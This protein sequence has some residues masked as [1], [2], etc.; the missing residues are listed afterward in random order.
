GKGRAALATYDAMARR[1]HAV[2]VIEAERIA[3]EGRAEAQARS[4][5]R[6]G[7]AETLEI[8]ADRVDDESI[9]APLGEGRE[10]VV[11]AREHGDARRIELL[12]E[13]NEP[14]AALAHLR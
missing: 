13:L 6:A 5:D 1:A 14:R 11:G 2:G 12:L 4:G 8:V 7:A 3:L 9:A 10:W